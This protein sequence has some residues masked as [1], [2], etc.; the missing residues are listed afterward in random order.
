MVK[1]IRNIIIILIIVIIAIIILLV[2]NINQKDGTTNSTQNELDSGEVVEQNKIIEVTDMNKYY[3]VKQNFDEYL[4]T[5]NTYANPY[6]EE[7]EDG[8]FVF[9]D[10]EREQFYIDV[11]NL[12][13]QEYLNENNITENNISDEFGFQ[14]K[15]VFNTIIDMKVCVN[16]NIEQ[17][18]IKYIVQDREYNVLDEKY[19]SIIMDI[20]N[21]TYEVIPEVDVQED[22]YEIHI[23]KNIEAVEANEN[24]KYTD[25]NI[26]T[27]DLIKNYLDF[28]KKVILGK[29][30][31][32]YDLLD[33]EYKQSR[34]PTIEDF[35]KYIQLNKTEIST[36][37]AEQF[38]EI[39]E[40][41]YIQYVIIDQ[42][43]KY[44]IFNDISVNKFEIILDVYSV[45]VEFWVD[46]YSKSS[47]TEKVA[48]NLAKIL[49]AVAN[50]DVE[51]IYNKLN[52]DYIDLNFNSDDSVYELIQTKFYPGMKVGNLNVESQGDVY[53]LTLEVLN[54]D[55][56]L[57][58]TIVL[59]MQLGE[60]QDFEI[61]IQK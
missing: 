50:R 51:Y 59:F 15:F 57:K 22:N 5:I 17:Y 7:R 54:E 21:K 23:L 8:S 27:T 52:K 20:N 48:S 60:N 12:V 39:E 18:I 41:G 47:D 16:E 10:E 34:F 11:Y 42:F 56:S 45:D 31:I 2:N 3:T 43:G 36:A 58:D 6:F 9:S 14:D 37:R 49:D 28:Y 46:E 55:D 29:S 19:I 35:N 24:N 1:N 61:S 40:D 32:I 38:K 44:Y 33:E 13:N 26:T 25:K 30:E 53:T 4:N